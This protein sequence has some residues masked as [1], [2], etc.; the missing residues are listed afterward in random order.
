MFNVSRAKETFVHPIHAY[1][2]KVQVPILRSR[3]LI[4]TVL[5]MGNPKLTLRLIFPPRLSISVPI[6]KYFKER[7]RKKDL[8]SHL[9][10]NSKPPTNFSPLPFRVSHFLLYKNLVT[11]DNPIIRWQQPKIWQKAQTFVP[12]KRVERSYEKK[13]DLFARTKSAAGA[14]SDCLVLT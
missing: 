9:E 12:E 3:Q 5:E 6:N 2:P 8:R 4:V 14:C 13:V 1:F 7:S 11:V 10:L